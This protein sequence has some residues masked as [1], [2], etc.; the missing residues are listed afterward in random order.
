MLEAGEGPA[1]EIAWPADAA[2]RSRLYLL[3][4][5]C[6]GMQT[7]LLGSDGALF[8]AHQPPGTA[9]QVNRDEI[10][11]FVRQPTGALTRAERSQIR[12]LQSRHSRPNATPVRVF[13]R[14][15]DAAVLGGL[16][17]IVGASYTGFRTIHARY[18]LAG[19]RISVVDVR[20][21]GGRRA[22]MVAV[23]PARRC[24]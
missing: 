9:W 1:I 14:A 13:P 3:F 12:A 20:A 11:G 15:V 6:Y 21:D 2:T 22:G 24:G 8:A 5:Q 7:A 10:S 16:R 17:Q 19:D 23:P 18:D 4:T